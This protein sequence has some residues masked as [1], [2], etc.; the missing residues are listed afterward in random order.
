MP[1]VRRELVQTIA[2]NAVAPYLVYTLCKPSLGSFAALALSAV[3][4]TAESIWSVARERRIDIISALVLSGIA[5]SL[6]LIALGGSERVLLLRE[7]FITAAI[8]LALAVSAL[9]GRPLLFYLL[10][11]VWSANDPAALARWT[12]RWQ[13]EPPLRR[14]MRIMTAV[15]G[16]WLILEMAVRTVM[17]FEMETSH[18]LLISPFVQYGLTGVLVVWTVMFMRR[19]SLAPD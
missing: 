11:Q 13:A 4:P 1:S 2:I 17:V 15:W 6:I 10:R 7:S 8:G 16:I 12:A 14:S 5:V 3:P 9:I 18:F 19:R